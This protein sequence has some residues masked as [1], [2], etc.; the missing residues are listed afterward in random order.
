[1][2]KDNNSSIHTLKNYTYDIKL[3][4]L[5]ACATLCPGLQVLTKLGELGL[6]LSPKS[7]KKKNFQ[8]LLF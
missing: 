5:G 8:D 7:P 3:V 6:S 2:L 4:N 1:M